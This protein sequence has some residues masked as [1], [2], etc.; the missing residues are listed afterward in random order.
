MLQGHLVSFY[1]NQGENSVG[2][3]VFDSEIVAN[4]QV[5]QLGCQE[6][7]VLCLLQVKSYLLGILGA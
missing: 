7:R 2:W 1:S 6:H 5:Q 3:L 4:L